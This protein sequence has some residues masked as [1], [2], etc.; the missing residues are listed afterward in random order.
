M[1][2]FIPLG[3]GVLTTCAA[4]QLYGDA[5]IL[6]NNYD[7]DAVI[8]DWDRKLAV[9]SNDKGTL[10]VQVLGG[11]VGF[12]LAPL[13]NTRGKDKFSLTCNGSLM[14]RSSWERRIP[15]SY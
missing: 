14:E 9:G 4:C 13:R 2:E 1:K 5:A 12:P 11:R 6:L 8:Y 3:V 10:W 7:S 15:R